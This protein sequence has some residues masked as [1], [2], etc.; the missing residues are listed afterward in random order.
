MS[1]Y[2]NLCKK[3]VKRH[4]I[5]STAQ[6]LLFLWLILGVSRFYM[7][8]FANE[9]K[10]FRG[11]SGWDLNWL[12]KG[13]QSGELEFPWKVLESN[14]EIA[15]EDPPHRPSNCG[16]ISL[17]FL[18][19]IGI[20][21]TPSSLVLIVIVVDVHS[22][23]FTRRFIENVMFGVLGYLQMIQFFPWMMIGEV[24]TSYLYCRF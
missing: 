11:V 20:H 7:L 4:L 1:M 5:V 17:G 9:G 10:D 15:W 16:V 8:I 13:S 18:A 22:R 6:N 3:I 19:S 21:Y 2:K 12:W 24:L 23:M 14:G